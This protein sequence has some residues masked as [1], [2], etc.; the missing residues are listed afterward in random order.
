MKRR[1]VII[2]LAMMV[3]GCGRGGAGS[4]VPTA[5]VEPLA[6][7]NTPEAQATALL[8]PTATRRVTAT[9]APTMTPSPTATPEPTLTPEPTWTPEP[10][11]EP[12]FPNYLAEAPAREPSPGR[13]TR[14]KTYPPGSYEF[15][16]DQFEV[17]QP[18][19]PVPADYIGLLP[20]VE[21]GRCPLRGEEGPE[22]IASRRPINARID[23]SPQGRPQAGLEDADVIW[24][25]LAEGG[26]TRLTA[27]FH[28]RQPGT[29]GPIRS[30]R[31][32]D[33]QLMPML[34]AWFVH[35]AASQPITD[36]LW[37]SPFADQ[38]I[39]EWGGDPAF[40]RVT[41]APVGWL[42]TY[43]NGDLIQSVINTRG[44]TGLPVPLRGWTFSD[45]PPAGAS[46]SA[47]GVFIPYQ[48]GTSS[49]VGYRFDPGSG[50]Y[51]RYQGQSPHS[52]QA[53]AHL[54]ADNVVVIFSE[55]TVTPIVEDSLGN[56]SL[57]FKLHG[58]G[59]ALLFRD[60]GVWDLRWVREG[61]NVLIRLVGGGGE[62][63]P[64]KPGQTW[65]QIVPDTLQV[66]W[67]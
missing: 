21:E 22:G 10:P 13:V 57:H 35:V 46:G 61:E 54:G 25:A 38:D 64:L 19:G 20:G 23:N 47:S 1:F 3:A 62:V 52:T 59:R 49:V 2:L 40:Y 41:G 16:H 36:M 4:P 7:M 65:V 12:V 53:G 67:E 32:V 37:A 63:I 44:D 9:L 39:D 17:P 5:T 42:S 50:R 48:A 18:P 30:G 60:G 31:L 6:S 66:T 24:E 58:E 26:I 27:T 15:I 28:C 51:L 29:L 45:T 43:S 56:L 34:Q 8:E 33:L 55:M 14:G 11:P